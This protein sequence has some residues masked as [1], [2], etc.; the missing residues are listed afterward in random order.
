MPPAIVYGE[1]V[2]AQ[3]GMIISDARFA[4][5]MWVQGDRGPE[6]LI[7]D[8]IG[9]LLAYEEANPGLQVLARYVHDYDTEEW[10]RADS[11]VYVSSR[12]IQSPMGHGLAAFYD[13]E[14]AALHVATADGK[15]LTFDELAT[16]RMPHD[17]PDPYP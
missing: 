17:R 15:A 6:S 3:C 10:I 16:E 5:A 9:D 12:D 8:D 2:C 7:F 11:A 14:S 4:S 13:A 1:D